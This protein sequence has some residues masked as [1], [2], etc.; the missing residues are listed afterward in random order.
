MVAGAG[1]KS[2]CKKALNG[3]WCR[4]EIRIF[5][6]CHEETRKN[7]IAPNHYQL[8]LSPLHKPTLH[9]ELINFTNKVHQS[10]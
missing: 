7:P 9:A 1:A 8:G 6:R 10:C 5:Q 3:G 2:Y 4:G